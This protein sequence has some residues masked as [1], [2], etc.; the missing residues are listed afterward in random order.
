MKTPCLFLLI[1][2]TLAGCAPHVTTPAW[3]PPDD[4][5][6]DG[7]LYR[8]RIKQGG[9]TRFSGLIGLKP[10]S[11]GVE[12]LLLD[13][14]G[15]PLVK[16]SARPD[17]T[18]VIEYAPGALREKRI[19]ELIGKLVKYIY[20]TPGTPDCSWHIPYQV[21]LEERE[22]GIR[23]KQAKFGPLRLWQVQ[24]VHRGHVGET[25][26]VETLLPPIAISLDRVT[27]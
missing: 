1:M 4:K 18:M 5:T 14:T 17:G 16:G 6:R 22:P 2:L 10:V 15:A 24:T 25:I 26:E 27:E 7:T 11:G 3:P 13:A 12:S 20:F 8:I 19:P 9:T 21:C 23:T